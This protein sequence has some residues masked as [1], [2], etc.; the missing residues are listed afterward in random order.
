MWKVVGTTLVMTFSWTVAYA[1]QDCGKA[2]TTGEA[3][4][5]LEK[6]IAILTQLEPSRIR[7][8]QET[9]V[10]AIVTASS[11]REAL[12]AGTIVPFGG[13]INE[14][15]RELLMPAGWLF[16]DG[17]AVSRTEYPALYAAIGNSWGNP[18]P[19]TFN[20]P[21]LTGRF[22]RGVDG[23]TA[24]DPDRG[25]RDEAKPGGN[26]GNSVGSIQ[27]DATRRPHVAFQISSSGQHSHS[28]T[29]ALIGDCPGHECGQ[30]SAREYPTPNGATTAG[31]GNHAHTIQTGGDAETRPKNAYVNFLIRY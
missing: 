18:G 28:Y 3:I 25:T 2:D 16:C 9:A 30:G 5:C 4:R 31:T 10:Q 6:K 7:E 1:E 11:Q 19:T 26:S 17:A 14:E 22:L 23:G 15:T 24:R 21:D 29:S 27:G 13:P 12:P 8:A 20:L